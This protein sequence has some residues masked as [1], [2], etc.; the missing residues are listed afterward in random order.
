MQAQIILTSSQSKRL[1]ARGIAAYEPVRQALRNGIVVVGRGTTN[2]YVAEEL[3]KKPFERAKFVAGRTAPAGVDSARISSDS[4]EVV[5]EKGQSNGMTLTEALGRMKTG[6]VFLKGANAINYDLGQAAVQIGHPTG[7][8]M[9]AVLGTLV[10]KRIR[11]IHPAGLEKSVPGDLAA[12]A[13]RIAEDGDLKGAGW[14]I[15]VTHGELFTEIEALETLFDV[16]A[17]PC[18]AGGILGAEGAVTIAVFGSSGEL[19]SMLMLVR[20]IQKE[21]PFGAQA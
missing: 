11:L 19:D 21:P 18:A 7:G 8:T 13:R 15:W 14:G 12:T 16:E 5:I 2:G 6:D 3:T 1:I 4:P 17:V 20:E 9:A 10:S